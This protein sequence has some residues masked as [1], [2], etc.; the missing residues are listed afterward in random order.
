[1]TGAINL[2]NPLFSATMGAYAS[3]AES[4]NKDCFCISL[5]IDALKRALQA[6][7]G[8][9]DLYQLIL[10][11]CPHLFADL[12]VF[13]SA[14][15]LDQMA[16]VIRA[17]ETVV[18]LPAY[19]E[20]VLGWAPPIA[21]FEPAGARGVFLSYDF[22]LGEAGPRLIEINTNAGGALLNAALG[23]AQRA[24]CAAMEGMTAGSVPLASIDASFLEMFLAEW[25]LARGDRVLRSV[26]IVDEKP[27]QQY[28][29]PE[30]LLF[31]Q[32][33]SRHGYQAIITDP[34]ELRLQDGT[35]WHGEVQIDLVYNRLT[36]FTLELPEHAALREAYLRDA[37]VLTPHPRAHA[38]YADKRN[39]AVLTDAER[40]RALGVSPE[41]ESTLLN[42]IPPTQI[43]DP[44]HADRLWSERRGLFFKPAA[45]YGSKAAYRG[46]KLT[47]RVWEAVLEGDYVAQAFVAPGKRVIQDFQQHDAPLALKFDIRNYV[48]DGAVQ[49][50]AARMYHGQTTNFRT[51]GGGFAPVFT[52]RG[53][54]NDEKAII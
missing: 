21:R 40:L 2:D 5:D 1:M 14:R 16:A 35:L 13:I 38:L 9:T 10:D 29:Y 33:F 52:M 34:G 37:V 42:G 49:F 18:R 7:P 17:V 22:H 27:E 31:R 54:A 19:R 44:A 30:F 3:A 25:R 11:R 20:K 6:D 46:D 12:P 43:V 32:L 4:L 45:G 51:P 48:Y 41:V 39:L 50:V 28:L 15:H 26:A 8:T 36:D 23:R 47:R 53:T 24:C